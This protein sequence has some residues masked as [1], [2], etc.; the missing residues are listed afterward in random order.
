MLRQQ[1]KI[2]IKALIFNPFTPNE[3]LIHR[4]KNLIDAA[5]HEKVKR[6]LMLSMQVYMYIFFKKKSL[7]ILYY[8][9]GCSSNQ[10]EDSPMGKFSQ[11]EGYLRDRYKYGAWVVFRIPLIQQFMHFWASMIENKSTIGLSMSESDYLL[12][13]NI[14]DV[15]ECV[16]QAALSKKCSVWANQQDASGSSD[17]DEEETAADVVARAAIKRVYELTCATPAGLYLI[18]KALSDAV[19]KDGF[20]VDIEATII[21]DEQ[22]ESYL[23]FVSGEKKK[24]L[25]TLLS[26]VYKD[27]EN[28]LK[29]ASSESGSL[30]KSFKAFFIDDK[31]KV[32]YDQDDPN[33]YPAPKVLNP[34]CID[35]IL[36]HF[37]NARSPDVPNMPSSD[38][39]DITGRAPIE[40]SE[41]FMENRRQFRP[42]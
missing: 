10:D 31:A 3:R 42:E 28:K 22:L 40:I 15:C 38:I 21:T 23:K 36:N 39:C 4:G 9:M 11:V 16:C 33:W 19:R 5:I 35:L 24:E 2:N 17:D 25:E 1:M 12:T 6:I 30:L 37:R 20:D 34:F 27:K 8:R 18:S 13:V 7:L 29:K 41:F 14:M 32:T 26:T